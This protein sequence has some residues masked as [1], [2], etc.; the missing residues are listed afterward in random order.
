M[1]GGFAYVTGTDP[2]MQEV[3]LSFLNPHGPRRLYIFQLHLTSRASYI[4][5]Y[6]AINM[7][8]MGTR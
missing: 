1:P 8:C 4:T 3:T 6:V 2:E 7:R 5:E